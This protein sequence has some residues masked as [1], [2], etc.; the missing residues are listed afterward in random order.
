LTRPAA[1]GIIL[2]G[3]R[4]TRL[5]QL[6]LQVPKPFASVAR[7]PFIEWVL[8]WLASNGVREFVISLGHLGEAGET[9]LTQRPADGLIVKWVREAAPLGTAG[10][11]V[12]AA[13]Q[14]PDAEVLVVA[15]GDSIVPINLTRAW[16][17]LEPASVDGAVVATRASDTS[18]FGRLAV[19][20][21]GTLA[22]LD[23]K[24][25]GVGLVSAG[26]YLLK[27]HLLE[28]FP[29]QRPLSFEYDMFP[30]WLRTGRKLRVHAVTAPLLDIGLPETL[31][32]A[33]AFISTHFGAAPR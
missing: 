21:D 2:A 25:A 20:E 1:S 4:G 12:L 19:N 16:E 15:N 28:G 9:Y 22:A 7:R 31:E 27:R 6:G 32:G 30:L 8:A 13:Q 11:F 10:G 26:V 23:E 3:G 14:S 24:T 33:E 5:A 17:M 29:D 18:R